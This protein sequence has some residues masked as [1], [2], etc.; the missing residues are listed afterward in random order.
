[1][2]AIRSTLQALLIIELDG[3]GHRVDQL[4]KRFETIALGCGS[5]TCQISN[6]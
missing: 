3:L 5:G 2:P 4:I 1:M 6:S